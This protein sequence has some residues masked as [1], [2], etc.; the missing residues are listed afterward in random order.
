MEEGIGN[1]QEEIEKAERGLERAKS[2][3]TDKDT[4]CK[5]H[6]LIPGMSPGK[7]LTDIRDRHLFGERQQRTEDLR[8]PGVARG[9]VLTCPE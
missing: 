2:L 8:R 9:H 6:L 1:Q 3:L 4:P 7:D 5:I